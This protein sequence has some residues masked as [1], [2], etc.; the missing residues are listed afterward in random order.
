MKIAKLSLIV[1]VAFALYAGAEVFAQKDNPAVARGNKLFI[2]YCASCHGV[3]AK[4]RGPVASSLKK[5]PSDLT[6]LQKGTKFPTSEVVKKI[7]GELG[8]PVH[9]KQDMPVWGL[10]FSQTDITNLVKYLETIQRAHEPE[11]AD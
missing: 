2:D 8:V 11:R 1:V 9:G 4:G 5:K 6:K 10:I 7:S 3:D